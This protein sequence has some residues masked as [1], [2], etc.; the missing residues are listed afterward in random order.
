MQEIISSRDVV[1]N[2]LAAPSVD[3][4]FLKVANEYMSGKSIPDIAYEL[5]TTPDRV[6]QTLERDDVKQY[7]STMFLSAG[8]ANV[9][10]LRDLITMVIENK[11][12][13]AAET[14]IMTKKD[15]LDWMKFAKELIEMERPKKVVPTTAIQVNNN[16]QS[17][18]ESLVK[19]NG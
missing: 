4:I 12:Q 1:A 18:I 11:L 14:G 19:D 6:A 15:L 2:A 9:H 3:P 13:E 16:Y 7:M 17:L 5:Q 10:K 8:F